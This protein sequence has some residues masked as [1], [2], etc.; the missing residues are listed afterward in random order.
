MQ[1][2]ARRLDDYI[3]KENLTPDAQ[4]FP[5][6]YSYLTAHQ[7]GEADHGTE[8]CFRS[9]IP[10]QVPVSQSIAEQPWGGRSGHREVSGE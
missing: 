4:V 3:K 8:E 10:F 1:W 9:L 6:S 2:V 5:I 7:F